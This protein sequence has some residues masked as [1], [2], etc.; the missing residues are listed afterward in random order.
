MIIAKN[1]ALILIDD[2]LTCVKNQ[3]EMKNAE[4]LQLKQELESHKQTEGTY[5]D[6]ITAN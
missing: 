6:Y 2:D 3:L 1:E 4:I 5:N